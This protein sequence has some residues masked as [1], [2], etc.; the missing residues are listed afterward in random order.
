[1]LHLQMSSACSSTGPI[2]VNV[3]MLATSR[4]T[5]ATGFDASNGDWCK[6]FEISGKV[7]NSWI[8]FEQRTT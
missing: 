8:E 2:D 6:C 5:A 1:M 3:V 4:E 7:S